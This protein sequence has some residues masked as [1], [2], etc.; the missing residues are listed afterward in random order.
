MAILPVTKGAENPIL[1]ALSAP[2]RRF[3]KKLKKLI[4]DMEDTMFDLNGVGIAAPQ[5]GVNLKLAL[6]RL[7]VDTKHETILIIANPEIITTS[8]DMTD[9]E[10]GCLSLPKQWGNVGRHASLTVT[11]QNIKGER[12]TLHLEGFNARVIQHEVDHLNG[13]LFI[14]RADYVNKQPSKEKKQD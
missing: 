14:D 11:F 7:N 12:L 5:V 1:R 13:K 3:D 4:Q 8:E 9:M 2:V 6:A 10:E